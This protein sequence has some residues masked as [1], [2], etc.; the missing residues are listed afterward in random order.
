MLQAVVI[1]CYRTRSRLLILWNKDSILGNNSKLS[2]SCLNLFA[3]IYVLT[4]F[5]CRQRLATLF[6]EEGTITSRKAELLGQ[7][8][9]LR[10]QI[11]NWH[12][13]QSIYM[14]G[15]AQLLERQ[16]L[17]STTSTL[18]E[19]KVLYLPSLIDLNIHLSC[20]VPGLPEIEC[21]MRLGQA[22]NA[23]NEVCRQL[24][25][26]SS[27]IQ[28]KRGQH[29]ASQQL[30]QKSRALMAKFTSKTHRATNRLHHSTCS[31]V[32]TG[33]W[34]E[35]GLMPTA[36]QPWEGPSLTEERRRWVGWGQGCSGQGVEVLRLQARRE[37][38]GVVLDLESST[39]GW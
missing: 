27:I 33:S 25:I 37:S 22:D 11:T 21:C 13:I 15:V 26:T 3:L 6:H 8:H 39:C 14:P 9:S 2:L 38:E 36:S 30:S 17:D 29:Q 10:H 12:E 24:H 7:H 18:L 32:H 34:W 5:F 31:T 28:F 4:L 20:C 1:R 23:L 19:V 35:L 16:L